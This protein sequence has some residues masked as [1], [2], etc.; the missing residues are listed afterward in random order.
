MARATPRVSDGVLTYQVGAEE[1]ATPVGSA[2]WWRWLAEEGT[3]SF[4]FAGRPGGATVRR[5]RKP[6]G[7]YWYAYRRRD[8]RLRKVY[9]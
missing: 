6:G 3:T 7:W 2:G 8:G 1:R 5:E 4:R 9:L